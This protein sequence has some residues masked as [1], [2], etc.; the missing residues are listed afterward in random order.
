M[1]RRRFGK[2]SGK[3]EELCLLDLFGEPEPFLDMH[4]HQVHGLDIRSNM[5]LKIRT[6]RGAWVRLSVHVTRSSP[7]LRII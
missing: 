5:S 3:H 7:G 1:G 4:P 2:L 6:R